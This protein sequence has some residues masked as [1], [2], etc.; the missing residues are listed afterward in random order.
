MKDKARSG[1]SDRGHCGDDHA[2]VVPVA[3]A[4]PPA[5]NLSRRGDVTD[6]KR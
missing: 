1:Y 4:S 3:Y 5:P 2:G 6:T